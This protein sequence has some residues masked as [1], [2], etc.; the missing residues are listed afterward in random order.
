MLFLLKKKKKDSKKIY[1]G[2]RLNVIYRFKGVFF[3]MIGFCIFHRN[4][5]L[6]VFSKKK[7]FS[8][9]F[10]ILIKNINVINKLATYYFNNKKWKI[11]YRL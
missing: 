9:Y 2:D 3:I 11:M 1:I 10:L 5:T 6:C 8:L 4:K 7:A